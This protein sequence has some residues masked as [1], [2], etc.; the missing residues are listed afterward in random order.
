MMAWDI[1]QVRALADLAA[2]K[3]VAELTIE[4]GETSITLKMP[5]AFVTSV[6]SS[7]GGS[8]AAVSP[9]A[10]VAPPPSVAPVLATSA[11][12][13]IAAVDASLVTITAPMVGTFYRASSPESP[14]FAEVGQRVSLGQTLCILEAMKQMNELECEQSG[15]ITAV[16]V[17]NGDPVE[18][19]KPLFT[20]RPD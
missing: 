2:E 8:V 18:Y 16:L 12:P 3:N 15:T 20:L 9:V 13:P 4:D 17:Q 5:S 19:G 10:V 11:P 14:P 1:E 6:A 7:G